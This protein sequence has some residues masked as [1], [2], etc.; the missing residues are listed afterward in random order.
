MDKINILFVMIYFI[1]WLIARSRNKSMVNDI[2]E[3]L[4]NEK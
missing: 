3:K 4:K 1:I 2:N